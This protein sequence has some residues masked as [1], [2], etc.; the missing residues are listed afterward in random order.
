MPKLAEMKKL[1]KQFGIGYTVEIISSHRNLGKLIKF[2]DKAKNKYHVIIG[3]ATSVANLPAIIAG[4]VK[5]A[6]IVVIGVGI[7]KKNLGGIDSLLS[8][9]SIP[10][11]IPILNSGI[12]EAGLINAGLTAIKILSLI[13]V[14][15]QKRRKSNF[16]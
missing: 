5:N 16:K 12:D 14:G 10:K 15:L 6:P 13:D 7:S 9:N 3:V 11:G 4:Y 2:L 8:V 1:F